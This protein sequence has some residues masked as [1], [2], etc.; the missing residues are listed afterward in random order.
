MP[1]HQN[2]LTS[3]KSFA[4][5]LMIYLLGM[6]ILAMGVSISI[7]SSLGVS[8]VSSIPYVA[9]LAF[10]VDQGVMITAVFSLYVFMQWLLL[11]KDFRL[12]SLLQIL[13]ASAFGYFV[14][15]CNFLLGFL[16]PQS[17]GSRLLLMLLSV[18]FIAWGILFYLAADLIPQ[19]AEGLVLA[20]IQKTGWK[21]STA[22]MGFDCTMVAIAALLSLVTTGTVLGLREGTVIAMLGVG[23]VLGPLTSLFQERIRMF[24]FGIAEDSQQPI[25]PAQESSKV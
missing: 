17:Y 25:S 10:Q 13:C 2:A 20:V 9:S 7:K 3:A 5:R 22:K 15:R 8:P 14:N 23:K 24:C 21:L 18:V 11:R 19:P 6:F 1:Q 4:R 16:H 12:I